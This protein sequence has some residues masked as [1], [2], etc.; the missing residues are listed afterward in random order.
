MRNRILESVESD[1][2]RS[3][4]PQVREGYNIKV[5]VRIK[6]GTKERIQIFEGLVIAAYGEGINKSIKVRK[7]SYGVGIERTF[8]L[9]SPLISHIDV[10]RKNKVRRAKLYYMRDLKGKSARL[11]E[12]K[13]PVTS[14]KTTKK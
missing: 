2:I 7:D 8:K 9:N 14:T 1:Q 3:D 5:H 13:S 4:L 6:E 11:K 12:I 10:L